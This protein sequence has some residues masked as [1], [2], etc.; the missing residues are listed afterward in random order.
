MIAKLEFQLDDFDDRQAH[1]RCVKALDMAIVLSNLADIKKE[2]LRGFTDKLPNKATEEV[3]FAVEL[4]FNRI[5]RSM[6]DRGIDIDELI[7]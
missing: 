7:S 5:Y 2:F 3:E 1:L 6:E 4:L